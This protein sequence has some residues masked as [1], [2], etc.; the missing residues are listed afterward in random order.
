MDQML[1]ALAQAQQAADPRP[2]LA[3]D[4]EPLPFGRRRAVLAGDDLD[5]VA[6]VQR[7]AKLHHA[8]VD[9]GADAAIP[10]WEWTA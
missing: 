7:R 4:D 5:L 10:D 8:A 2:R 6:I 3:G 1:L 9:L